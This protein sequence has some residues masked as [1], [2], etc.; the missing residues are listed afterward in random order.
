MSDSAPPSPT[1]DARPPLRFEDCFW[2]VDSKDP[3]VGVRSL[4]AVFSQ[5]LKEAEDL[6]SL[7]KCRIKLEEDD[8][9]RTSDV[10]RH[11]GFPPP[12][13]PSGTPV[14]SLMEFEAKERKAMNRR[15]HVPAFAASTMTGTEVPEKRSLASH[16]ASGFGSAAA[17][18]FAGA[19]ETALVKQHAAAAEEED[20]ADALRDG[21]SLRPVTRMLV[22]QISSMSRIHRRH[23]DTLTLAVASPLQAFI[24]QNRRTMNKKKA[25]VDAHCQRLQALAADI[26]VRKRAY[27]EKSKIA[28]DEVKKFRDDAS[29][30]AAAAARPGPIA[31]GS[32]YMEVGELHGLVSQLQQDVRTRSITTPV[33][34]FDGAFIGSDLV[35]SVRK[36]FPALPVA[37]AR[38]LCSEILSRRLISSVVGGITPD[39]EPAIPYQFG[40]ALLKT[41]EFPHAKASR[42]AADVRAE[43]ETAIRTA[44]HT[45]SALDF[46]ITAYLVAAQKAETYR[47][48]IVRD[49]LVALESTQLFAAQE[50]LNLWTPPENTDQDDTSPL[51]LLP[52]PDPIQGVQCLARKHRTGH[53]RHHPFVFESYRDGRAPHQVFGIGLDELAAATT[54]PILRAEFNGDLRGGRVSGA[55][56]GRHG[57]GVLVAVLKLFLVE[58]PGSLCSCDTYETMKILYS[59]DFDDFDATVRL[60]SVTSLLSTI[61]KPHYETLKLFAAYL[62]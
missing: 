62:S 17:T 8:A 42:D 13:L 15:S 47:L 49:C 43:Y 56:L 58:G 2:G 51:P 48:S 54:V 39:F 5:N 32:R 30:R 11:F 16:I 29:K 1:V 53:V 27:M 19:K 20:V 3:T 6:L 28:E 36:R 7:V 24:E 44:E 37:D 60:K 14:S 21:S 59:G 31:V 26:E 33:G 38:A 35:D 9:A 50:T 61:S 18:L 46:H 52:S 57:A 4:H 23:A 55:M 41:G 40:R 34:L 12:P 25:E 10:G 22:D 45:R